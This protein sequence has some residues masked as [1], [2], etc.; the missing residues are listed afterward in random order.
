M[1]QYERKYYTSSDEIL[2]ASTKAPLTYLDWLQLETTFD[3]A[4]AFEQYTIYLTDWYNQKGISSVEVQT[5][6]VR[7]LY[8]NLLKQI[9]LDYTTADE[10][11]FLSNIDYDNDQDLDIALPFFTKKLKQIAIYYA[12]QRDELKY[13]PIKAN[14][15]GSSFGIGELIYKKI[16]DTLNYDPDVQT[17]LSNLDLTLVEVLTNLKIDIVELFDTEQNYYNIPNTTDKQ[18]YSSENSTRFNYF[19]MSILPDRAKLFIIDTYTESLI[20]LIKEVPVMLTTG[21]QTR[22]GTK[23]G[24]LQD[25]NNMTLAISDIITGTELDRLDDSKFQDYTQQGELNIS[26][27]QLAFQKYSGTDYYYLSTGDTLADTASGKL[28]DATQPHKELLNRFYPTVAATRGENLYKKQYIGGF[29]GVTGVGL[30]NYTTFDY[31]YRYIP[32]ENKTYYFPDPEAGA[33]G[34]YGSYEDFETP[35]IYY[36]NVNWN[37]QNV[38]THYNYGLQRQFKNVLRMNAYQST[39]DS[40]KTPTDG[41]SRHVDHIDFWN[42]DGTNTWTQQD[43]FELADDYTQPITPRQDELLVGDKTVYKWKTDI[44]GNNYILTKTG[45]DSSYKTAVNTN[46][47]IYQTEY[48]VTDDSPQGSRSNLIELKTDP[49]HRHESENLTDQKS[50]SGTLYMRNNTSTGVQQLTSASLSG[51]YSKYDSEGTICYRDCLITLKD[52][53]DSLLNDLIDIDIIYDTIIFETTE[54]IVFEKL[55]YDY[56]TMTI[57]SGTKDFAYV[58]KN[59]HTEYDN[60]PIC[61]ANPASRI[62]TNPATTTTTTTMSTTTTSIAKRYENTSNWWFEEDTDRILLAKTAVHRNN[63]A[64]SNRM[65]YPEIYAYNI[66]TGKL[67][68]SY[69]DPDYTDSQLIYETAQYS[70]SAVSGTDSSYD[71]VTTQQ[72]VFTYNKDSERFSIVYTGHDPVDNMYLTKTDF[73]L[74]DETIELININLYKNKYTTY[75][76]NAYDSSIDDSYLTETNPG[77][78]TSDTYYHDTDR[79]ILFMCATGTTGPVPVG[80]SSCVWTHGLVSDNYIGERNACISFDFAMCGTVDNPTA[81]PDGLS[82]LFY[83]ARKSGDSGHEIVDD[84]G[85]GGG[86]TY[87]PNTGV[88]ASLSGLDAGHACVVLDAAGSLIGGGDD[89]TVFGP[90]DTTGT[91]RSTKTL[92]GTDYSLYQDVSGKDYTDLQ[93]TRCKI[94][95]NDLGRGIQVHMKPVSNDFSEYELIHEVDIGANFGV[96]YSTPRRLKVSLAGNTSTTNNGIIAIRN[97]TVTASGRNDEEY[98][99]V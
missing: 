79:D 92:T 13:S 18:E 94:T 86:F 52:I 35:V 24:E 10:K 8:I 23:E 34:F 68:R 7:N 53:K 15:K 49:T 55:K 99:I 91:F 33:A 47:N 81:K 46:S 75:T 54:Y 82:V 89:I 90:Y 20:E 96:G 56:T 4:T 22:T 62:T 32:V 43:I 40:L 59:Y 14:L 63:S 58:K 71:I 27:E 5:E 44:Y 93:Y 83:N 70:L 64:S 57:T 73:R 29:F 19:S 66:K 80:D 85:T 67:A 88:D 3:K 78:T 65:V 37:K 97:I 9:A 31:N 84:G 39:S 16:T 6:Y 36:E 48:I 30:V 25:Q 17:Q 42:P 51:I 95:L 69:P 45:I 98:A 74:Y 77:L 60:L 1:S 50:L 2:S 26:Y 41:V 21:T 72:P 28:F 61:S 11:R 38:T 87:L 76:M 12:S